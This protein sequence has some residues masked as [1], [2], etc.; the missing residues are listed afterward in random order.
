MYFIDGVTNAALMHC[1]LFSLYLLCSPRFKYYLDVNMPIK[2][3]SEAYF[4]RLEV[5]YEPEISDSGPQ[6]KVPPGGL[7]LRILRPEKNPSTSAGFEH[8]NP[9]S[10]GEHVIPRPLKPTIH[11][12]KE[13]LSLVITSRVS[14][15]MSESNRNA[16]S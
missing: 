10:R 2:F 11:S 8:A 14:K 13:S 4:F 1:D 6:L 15:R 3:C 5:L 12:L 7:I 16:L 9:G